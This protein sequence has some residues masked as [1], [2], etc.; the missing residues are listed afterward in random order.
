MRQLSKRFIT[1][2]V[3]HSLILITRAQM[4]ARHETG[5][6][7]V[8]TWNNNR[9]E[10][11]ISIQNWNKLTLSFVDHVGSLYQITAAKLT[12]GSEANKSFNWFLRV[13]KTIS[14]VSSKNGSHN[15][16]KNIQDKKKKSVAINSNDFHELE[17]ADMLEKG[18]SRVKLRDKR[19]NDKSIYNK[20]KTKGNKSEGQTNC[21]Q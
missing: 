15:V 9:V 20:A 3:I 17:M 8:P 21:Y 12:N 11:S 6:L 10:Q 13:F 19:Y 14:G 7:K 1:L 16:A 2:V 5:E 4:V 18:D